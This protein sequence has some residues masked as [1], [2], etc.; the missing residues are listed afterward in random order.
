MAPRPRTA[1]SVGTLLLLLLLA[2]ASP[3]DAAAQ[4]AGRA[5]N[6]KRREQRAAE[7]ARGRKDKSKGTSNPSGGAKG[8]KDKARHAA[9]DAVVGLSGTCED[10]TCAAA[11][12]QGVDRGGDGPLATLGEYLLVNDTDGTL[13]DFREGDGQGIHF[14]RHR[15][16]GTPDH[17]VAN[18]PTTHRTAIPP[19]DP[20]SRP[21]ATTLTYSPTSNA[22]PLPATAALPGS[23][24]RWDWG[25]HTNEVIHAV[26]VEL[27]LMV[28]PVQW[29]KHNGKEGGER[30]VLLA[31]AG[32]GAN[33]RSVSA[34]ELAVTFP[35]RVI[36]F[37]IRLGSDTSA[38]TDH[39]EKLVA[40]TELSANEW[41]H[42]VVTYN[43]HGG[44]KWCGRLRIY[45]DGQQ[46]NVWGFVEQADPVAALRRLALL[47]GD[48]LGESVR[49]GTF[50]FTLQ[51]IRYDTGVVSM[52]WCQRLVSAAWP[53][54]CQCCVD[55]RYILAPVSNGFDT[56]RQVP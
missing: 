39:I 38:S 4:D 40:R 43:D 53:A 52:G 16:T 22:P 11:F 5:V 56:R 19:V 24:G 49:E 18:P 25:R 2:A 8:S 50:N 32:P 6:K 20:T 30:V 26:S 17:Q 47:P 44:C 45:V 21:R 48:M 37:G 36:D 14:S 3:D 54:S 12:L 55:Q 31:E 23:W 10:G 42:V 46:D 51:R 34:F 35:K 41:H 27:W 1:T 9:A 29:T 28:P 33:G 15:L 7:R 13:L